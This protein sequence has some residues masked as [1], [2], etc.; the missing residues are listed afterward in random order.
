MT[1]KDRRLTDREGNPV[2]VRF[3]CI[4]AVIEEK[5]ARKLIKLLNEDKELV[6]S[7][8]QV[9]YNDIAKPDPVYST[10]RKREDRGGKTKIVLHPG[11]DIEKVQR[12]LDRFHP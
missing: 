4:K 5:D 8:N 7:N 6:S 2:K 9:K 10:E 3:P 1:E 12:H 11:I